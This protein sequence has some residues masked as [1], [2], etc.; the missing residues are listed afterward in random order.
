MTSQ[1]RADS[2]PQLAR[3][4]R[5]REDA[6]RGGWVLLGP[7]RVLQPDPVAVE[8][9]KRL[10]GQRSL[11]AIIEGL[12]RDFTAD[13]AQ[14][15]KDVRLFLTGLAEKGLLEFHHDASN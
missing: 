7:E 3:G 15:E 5:L 6:A 11:E 2:I 1:I 12:A 4:V 9:L 10:D 14:I 8:I 13:R